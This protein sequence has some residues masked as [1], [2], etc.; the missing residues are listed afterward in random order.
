MKVWETYAAF[1]G[2]DLTRVG[3]DL[4]SELHGLLSG[5]FQCLVV[6]SHCLVQVRHLRTQRS[7]VKNHRGQTRKVL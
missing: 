1:E 6:F 2:V 5:L 4:M 3:L 7:L